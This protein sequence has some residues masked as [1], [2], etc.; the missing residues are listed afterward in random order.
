MGLGVGLAGN[1]LVARLAPAV[2]WLWWN[3]AGFGSTVVAALLL[4]RARPTL[5][6]LVW[7]RRESVLLISALLTMLS[8][9]AL[10]Q[11]C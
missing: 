3:P 10:L 1:L 2:S 11:Q 4:S 6:T 5:A 8:V 9:L 7:P